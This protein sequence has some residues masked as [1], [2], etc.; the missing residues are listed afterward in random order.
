MYPSELYRETK[1][2]AYETDGGMG[3]KQLTLININ[4]KLINKH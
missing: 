2:I 3:G 4:L 1:A